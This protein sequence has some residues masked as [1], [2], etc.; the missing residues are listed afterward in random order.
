LETPKSILHPPSILFPS[1]VES[2]LVLLTRPFT[3]WV[4]DPLSIMHKLLPQLR[5]DMNKLVLR[6]VI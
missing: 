2:L 1:S 5:N 6:H 3:Y 4:L